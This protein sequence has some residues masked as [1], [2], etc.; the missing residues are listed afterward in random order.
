MEKAWIVCFWFMKAN[1]LFWNKG[2]SMTIASSQGIMTRNILEQAI[3]PMV[4]FFK[5]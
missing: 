3:A 5:R 4:T 2:A 1:R